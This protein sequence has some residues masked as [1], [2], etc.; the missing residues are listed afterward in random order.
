MS[1]RLAARCA[2][3]PCVA[4]AHGVWHTWKDR[5]CKETRVR[6]THVVFAAS[7]LLVRDAPDPR[8]FDGVGQMLDALAQDGVQQVS[9]PAL[10]TVAN[11]T[12]VAVLA[13]RR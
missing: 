1:W 7:S 5:N 9:I 12:P 4:L 13:I 2:C 11:L 10:G 3:R 6:Y 8:P